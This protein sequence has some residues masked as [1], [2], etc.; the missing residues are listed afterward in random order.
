[1]YKTREEWLHAAAAEFA[2]HIERETGRTVPAI[3]IGIGFPSAGIRSG[4]IGECWTPR[5]S[6]DGTHEI[7][8]RADRTPAGQEQGLLD[9]LLH[10]MVHAVAGIPAGHGPEFKA[11]AQAVGLG[12]RMTATVPMP[13][14]RDALEAWAQYGSIGR[15]PMA[16][17][18]PS[19][20]GTPRRPRD[21]G[22]GGD[23]PFRS[24]PKT[25]PTRY[26]KASCG[27]EYG[28]G[29]TVR[30]VKKWADMGLPECPN[31]ECERK[32]ETLAL[33]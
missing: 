16:T 29:Y 9:V 30:I 22:E 6:A 18:D 33:A 5:A 20:L 32:G 31:P 23:E 12:G 11:I 17:F 21:P 19:G 14:L 15:Y 8:I 13:D 27:G 7:F 1:M 3:R 24:G 25:Q 4:V 2:E 28:C 10:E 26:L